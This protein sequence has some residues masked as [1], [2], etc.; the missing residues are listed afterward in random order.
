MCFFFVIFR[1]F[2]FASSYSKWRAP[3]IFDVFL[4]LD[5]FIIFLFLLCFTYYCSS[6]CFLFLFF[7]LPMFAALTLSLSRFKIEQVKFHWFI[8]FSFKSD[9]FYVVNSFQT[10]LVCAIYCTYV[11]WAKYVNI[12]IN[13]IFFLLFFIFLCVFCANW[14]EI[15]MFCNYLSVTNI[16]LT[17]VLYD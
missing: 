14:K 5:Y 4:F 15:N 9:P 12:N 2:F 8:H 16:H 1:K 17:I 6:L 3:F 13:L 11:L 7:N 10:I